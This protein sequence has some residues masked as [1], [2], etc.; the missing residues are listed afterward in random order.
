M[1]LKVISDSI[2]LTR[3]HSVLHLELVFLVILYCG[4]HK[5]H[6]VSSWPCHSVLTVLLPCNFFNNLFS[7]G[8]RRVQGIAELMAKSPST[9]FFLI[10]PLL[11]PTYL[12]IRHDCVHFL[13]FFFS[14]TGHHSYL[15][16]GRNDCIV[17]K[18]RRKNCP[19][20]R[21]RKCYQAG[22]MLGGACWLDILLP[23]A[24]TYLNLSTMLHR[25][26][27]TPQWI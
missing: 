5:S 17:D 19:A 1:S 18:I 20:C 9:P 2:T 6:Y 21:L 12:K 27:L 14:S 26:T 22:M 10:M 23:G 15:C 24:K 4:I 16:A 13:Y 3:V 11:L 7:V 8:H 25:L